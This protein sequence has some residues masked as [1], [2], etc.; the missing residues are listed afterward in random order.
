MPVDITK[1]F[2]ANVKA[3]RISLSDSD[4]KT[5]LLNEELFGKSK[6][7]IEKD[8]E[9]QLTT[10]IAKESRFIVIF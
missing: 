6:K 7:K 2:K 4:D 5:E 1:I 9:N 8:K 3:I 10:T